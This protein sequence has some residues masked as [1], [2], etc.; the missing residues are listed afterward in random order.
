[1]AT[2]YSFQISVLNDKLCL[3]DIRV[4]EISDQANE[5]SNLHVPAGVPI[6]VDIPNTT[7]TV[8]L[9]NDSYN[10]QLLHDGFRIG[11]KITEAYYTTGSPCCHPVP[12]NENKQ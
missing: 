11:R 8:V 2:L 10:I 6:V 12:N 7:S 5:E 4:H 3:S 1:M 9:C